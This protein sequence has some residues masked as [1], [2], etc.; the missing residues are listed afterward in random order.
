MFGHSTGKLVW[1]YS[2]LFMQLTM[3]HFLFYLSANVHDH[4]IYCLLLIICC[5][6][7]TN[8]QMISDWKKKNNSALNSASAEFWAETTPAHTQLS[9]PQKQSYFVMENAAVGGFINKIEADGSCRHANPTYLPFC[10]RCGRAVNMHPGEEDVLC[11]EQGCR[12]L[13]HNAGLGRDGKYLPCPWSPCPSTWT[14]GGLWQQAGVFQGWKRFPCPT[15]ALD[16]LPET[17]ARQY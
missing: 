16:W 2:Q 9:T 8:V 5:V 7:N 6:R 10:S 12:S 17:K 3:K 15:D 11:S 14:Q 4:T 13:V 1:V